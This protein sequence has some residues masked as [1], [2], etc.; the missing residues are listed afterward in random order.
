MLSLISD[1]TELLLM[2]QP[3][4]GLDIQSANYVW[5]NLISTKVNKA[6]TMFSS[7]D[8]DEI[9]EYSEY[10]ICFFNNTIVAHGYPIDLTKDITMQK[11]SGN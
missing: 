6:L 3:T 11:I 8:I 5:D 7:T 9:Y 2:E 10:I 1:S 4:R